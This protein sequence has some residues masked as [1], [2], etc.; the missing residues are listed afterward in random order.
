MFEFI[1]TQIILCVSQCEKPTLDNCFFLDTELI[2]TI[3]KINK[4]YITW[5]GHLFDNQ[6]TDRLKFN[7]TVK[8]NYTPVVG[9]HSERNDIQ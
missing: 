2:F 1:L 8:Q 3:T 5:T 4:F 7:S 9:N 6:I